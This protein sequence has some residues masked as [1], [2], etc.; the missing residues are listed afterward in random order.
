MDRLGG[1][2][3]CAF[4]SEAI[5]SGRVRDS[6]G[7]ALL[8]KQLGDLSSNMPQFDLKTGAIKQKKVKKEKTP[9][10]EAVQGLKLLEKK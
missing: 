4:T 6:A 8:A 3:F 2:S 9:A 10:E 5:L 1:N 7:K